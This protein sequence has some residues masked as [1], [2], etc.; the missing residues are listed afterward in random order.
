[1]CISNQLPL[2]STF[3][4]QTYFNSINIS[5]KSQKSSL[6][7]RSLPRGAMVKLSG[8]FDWIRETSP[9]DFS[10]FN[11]SIELPVFTEKLIFLLN[12][13]SLGIF[14][15]RWRRRCQRTQ[16]LWFTL[17]TWLITR[18]TTKVAA[19][20]VWT[21]SPCSCSLS[22]SGQPWLFFGFCFA[23][24]F[25]YPQRIQN[26]FLSSQNPYFLSL[27]VFLLFLSHL[28]FMLYVYEWA[29]SLEKACIFRSRPQPAAQTLV[30]SH[31]CPYTHI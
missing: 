17:S 8:S 10:V 7:Q 23:T 25:V 11:T 16:P 2:R 6:S 24:A 1:M 13:L 29:F 18:W 21:L 3:T 5:A 31:A 19:W 14:H 9:A 12:I 30:T 20:T 27:F 26:Q 28:S 22:L 4:A 15:R